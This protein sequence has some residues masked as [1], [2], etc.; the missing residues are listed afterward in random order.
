MEVLEGMM[1]YFAE[2]GFTHVC[3]QAGREFVYSDLRGAYVRMRPE[4]SEV[5]LTVVDGFINCSTGNLSFPNKN[6]PTF[7]KRLERHRPVEDLAR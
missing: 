3:Y 5:E 2:L 6:I 4:K 7:L 1:T